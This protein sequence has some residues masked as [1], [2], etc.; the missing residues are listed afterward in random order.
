VTETPIDETVN[1]EKETPDATIATDEL[2]KLAAATPEGE[3][4]EKTIETPEE[5]IETPET[6]NGTS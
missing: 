2:E 5:I 1:T 6:T 4:P 3:V